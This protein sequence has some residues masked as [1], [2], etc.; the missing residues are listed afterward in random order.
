MHK[1]CLKNI[2]RRTSFILS[3][4]D[5]LKVDIKMIIKR[6]EDQYKREK[7]EFLAWIK[8]FGEYERTVLENFI[9]QRDIKIKPT[10][11]GMYFIPLKVA[12]VKLNSVILLRSTM[13]VNF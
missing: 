13:K 2:K 5:V 4:G 9:E 10:E 3:P 7:E 1:D 11:S 8:D 6:T 12:T